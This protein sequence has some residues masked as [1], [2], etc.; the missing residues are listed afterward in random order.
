[1]SEY[2]PTMEQLRLEHVW[3]SGGENPGAREAAGEDFDTALAAHDRGVKAEALAEFEQ[4]DER[5]WCTKACPDG[6]DV[7]VTRV[8]T[9]REVIE[10]NEPPTDEDIRQIRLHFGIE[11]Q[12]TP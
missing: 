11:S 1:M 2:V 7:A 12:E 6:C 9:R 5:H 8:W 4:Y 10:R 3:L